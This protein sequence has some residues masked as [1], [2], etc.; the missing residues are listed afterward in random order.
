MAKRKSDLFA[1]LQE[2]CVDV[3]ASL[4]KEIGSRD[5]NI[6]FHDFLEKD[7]SG[8]SEK[9]YEMYLVLRNNGYVDQDIFQ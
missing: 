1:T 8:V 4:D 9:L 5:K 3:V 2:K 7:T 6:S